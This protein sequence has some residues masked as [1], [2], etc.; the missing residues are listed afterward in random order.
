MRIG[1]Q[2]PSLRVGSNWNDKMSFN[3]CW[4]LDADGDMVCPRTTACM[5]QARCMCAYE[6]LHRDGVGFLLCAQLWNQVL[7]SS[8]SREHRY[9]HQYN[10]NVIVNEC[11]VGFSSG[12]RLLISLGF[13]RLSFN[14]DGGF[15]HTCVFMYLY[16]YMYICV[17]YMYACAYVCVYVCMHVCL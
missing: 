12:S 3:K 11:G 6:I 1:V 13:Q 16:V 2:S 9:A 17:I 14:I 8:A 10:G 7:T 5:V 4:Y 15:E